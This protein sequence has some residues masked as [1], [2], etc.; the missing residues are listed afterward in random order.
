MASLSNCF[1]ILQSGDFSVTY[2]I[3]FSS[4]ASVLLLNPASALHFDEQRTA[5]ITETFLG[6]IGQFLGLL[7][8]N[9]SIERGRLRG[10]T[11]PKHTAQGL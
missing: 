11:A 5:S 4:C 2:R 1:I 8:E 6:L 7:W 9:D 10:E 3:C